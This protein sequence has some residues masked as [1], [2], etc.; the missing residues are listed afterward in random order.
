MPLET[1]R[2]IEI[3]APPGEVF[4]WLIEPDKL[5]VWTDVESKFPADS[6][7]LHV[8]YKLD[9]A[10]QAPDG[11]REFELEVTAYDPPREFG[12]VKAQLAQLPAMQRQMAEQQMASAMKQ[13]EAYSAAE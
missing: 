8:G 10:F 2:T 1:T 5:K 12:Y 6:S 9:G 13:M 3:G 4:S 11:E 7:E